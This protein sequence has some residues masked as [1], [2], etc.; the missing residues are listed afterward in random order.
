MHIP[1]GRTKKRLAELQQSVKTLTKQHEKAS[2]SVHFLIHTH[3]NERED[4]TSEI[5]FLTLRLAQQW[6]YYER[7]NRA[8]EIEMKDSKLALSVKA[9]ELCDMGMDLLIRDAQREVMEGYLWELA[10]RV[11]YCEMCIEVEESRVAELEEMMREVQLFLGA[12]AVEELELR[13]EVA[14]LQSQHQN[15]QLRFAHSTNEVNNLHGFIKS[16]QTEK[17][18]L[19]SHL[20]AVQSKYDHTLAEL[21]ALKLQQSSISHSEK[22][23]ATLINEKVTL[24]RSLSDAKEEAADMR[25]LYESRLRDME[26]DFATKL[27]D[28]QLREKHLQSS[29]ETLIERADEQLLHEE[30]LRGRLKLQLAKAERTKV[31]QQR[32]EISTESDQWKQKY[33]ALLPELQRHEA[34]K[35]VAEGLRSE[36]RRLEELV[37]EAGLELSASKSSN[38][39]IHAR[40]VDLTAQIATIKKEATTA[41]VEVTRLATGTKNLQTEL[42]AVTERAET[43]EKMLKFSKTHSQHAQKEVTK[44]KKQVA[45]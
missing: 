13:T 32:D 22:D 39:S 11:W 6:H 21:E 30:K 45:E 9:E 44:Y 14:I 34:E 15:L 12:K 25:T 38:E 27:E 1:Q 40:V 4:L 20:L 29:L 33:E 16:L 24:Q 43:L 3:V 36:N 5:Q 31:E 37:R 26:L 28:S 2:E 17:Q 19:E 42:V 35:R 41:K 18:N 7:C 10:K 23:L 8:L